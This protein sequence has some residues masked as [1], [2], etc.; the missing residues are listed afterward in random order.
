MTANAV[1]WTAS[2]HHQHAGFL[3]SRCGVKHADQGE[4][5]PSKTIGFSFIWLA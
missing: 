2:D 4:A 5:T 1:L 3:L